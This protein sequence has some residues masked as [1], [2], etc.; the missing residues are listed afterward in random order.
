MSACHRQYGIRYNCV[1]HGP[2]HCCVCDAS[3]ASG[4]A[5]VVVRVSTSYWPS[6]G[7]PNSCTQSRYVSSKRTS[8]SCPLGQS[9]PLSTHAVKVRDFVTFITHLYSVWSFTCTSAV[10]AAWN[11]LHFYKLLLNYETVNALIAKSATKAFCCHFVLTAE[12]VPLS[13]FSPQTPAVEKRA[14]ATSLLALKPNEPCR[15]P[16]DR[17]GTGFGKPSFPDIDLDTTL[18]DLVGRWSMMWTVGWMIRST[19][20]RR[21]MFER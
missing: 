14:L 21:S 4:S 3:A 5:A 7:W 12:M 8:T 1:E 18:A 13:L 16:A 19:L 20:Q 11:D 2:R 9:R 15:A 10:D 17:F 6:D